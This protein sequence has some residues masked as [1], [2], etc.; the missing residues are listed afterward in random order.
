MRDGVQVVSRYRCYFFF[1]N[2][3]AT[4]EIYTLSL[5]D[6]LPISDRVFCYGAQSSSP[7]E[8]KVFNRRERSLTLCCLCYL[9]LKLCAS[10]VRVY[11]PL[12]NHDP[13]PIRS[14]NESHY[15]PLSRARD[16]GRGSAARRRRARGA[17]PPE[18]RVPAVDRS[19]R[20][21]FDGR[22]MRAAHR[23]GDGNGRSPW[24]EPDRPRDSRSEQGHRLEHTVAFPL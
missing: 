14:G 23:A 10:C 13:G 2:D 3:T 7:G 9:R 17:S 22:R 19:E 15:L 11:F 12:T 4:T 16:T 21:G 6:A 1:V 8:T 5:H 24:R 20:A 18:S